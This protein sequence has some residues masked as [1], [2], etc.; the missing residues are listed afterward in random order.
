MEI[1]NSGNVFICMK[2]KQ[3]LRFVLNITKNC[4][5]IFIFGFF[6]SLLLHSLHIPDPQN[7][8]QV[9]K[10]TYNVM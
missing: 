7:H 4:L 3:L 10:K 9:V 2:I 1:E 8:L 6:L 5:A